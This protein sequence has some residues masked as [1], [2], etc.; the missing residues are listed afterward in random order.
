MY[1]AHV[2]AGIVPGP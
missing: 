1:A 2:T